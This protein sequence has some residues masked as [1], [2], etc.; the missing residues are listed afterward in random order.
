MLT[1]WIGYKG[2]EKLNKNNSKDIGCDVLDQSK[3]FKSLALRKQK[4]GFCDFAQIIHTILSER[5]CS[6]QRIP[7][8]FWSASIT[9]KSS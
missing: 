6:V 2:Y 1:F 3:K 8:Y 4:K 5:K 9:E 7:R